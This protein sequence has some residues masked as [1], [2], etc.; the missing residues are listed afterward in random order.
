MF[1]SNPHSAR[2]FV[3]LKSSIS[4]LTFDFKFLNFDLIPIDPE[5][6]LY[7]KVKLGVPK[8]SG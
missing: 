4:L 7:L 2:Q 5:K 3:T 6:M 8:Y 1:T